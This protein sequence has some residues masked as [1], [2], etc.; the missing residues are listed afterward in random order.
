MFSLNVAVEDP[1]MLFFLSFSDNEQSLAFFGLQILPSNLCLLLHMAFLS[2]HMLV[3]K[4]CSLYKDMNH[5]I[6]THLNSVWPH[7]K[8]IT[9]ANEAGGQLLAVELVWEV[10]CGSLISFTR[11]SV[12][13]YHQWTSRS[14]D[15]Q[16]IKDLHNSIK[17]LSLLPCMHSKGQVC[18]YSELSLI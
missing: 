2:V 4:F 15:R 3:F 17:R 12:L 9:S 16:I 7:L 14:L 5:W 18:P 11:I 13:G 10:S 8:L 6:K 1:S